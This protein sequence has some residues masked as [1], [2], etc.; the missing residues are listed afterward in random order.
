MLGMEEE[1]FR[2]R[3]V[4]AFAAAGG[5]GIE[6]GAVA[7]DAGEPAAGFGRGEIGA[8]GFKRGEKGGLQEI[9]GFLRPAREAAGL[10]VQV[11]EGAGAGHGA[12]L[13]HVRD[14]GNGA[15]AGTRQPDHD[16]VWEHL[17][18]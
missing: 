17:P 16:H 12:R 15:I 7:E 8:A 4:A 18:C 11:C 10:C 14:C 3:G 9:V 5:A 2:P 13:A 1:R 6:G